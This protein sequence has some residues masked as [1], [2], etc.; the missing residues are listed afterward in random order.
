MCRMLAPRSVTSPG[1]CASTFRI[2]SVAAIA[3]TPS[4][5]ASSRA[6]LTLDPQRVGRVDVLEGQR[7]ELEVEHRLQRG[8]R[9]RHDLLD[10]H[11]PAELAR[12]RREGGVLGPA[13]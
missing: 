3:K 2:N 12:D 5:K 9:V 11:R 8:D 4:A 10:R 1:I 13:G 7:F 6:G